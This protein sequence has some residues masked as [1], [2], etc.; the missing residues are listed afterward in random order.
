M[1]RF[2]QWMIRHRVLVILLSLLLLIPAY[3][4]MNATKVKYDILYY[5]PQDLDTVKGQELL[6]QEF[7]KGAFSLG[8][9][10][11]LTEEQQKALEKRIAAV[12]H[13]DSV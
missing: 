2:T 3:L 6:I 7:G 8:I 11:G 10:Q 1:K 13:V 4:G 12:P 5:L 9:T